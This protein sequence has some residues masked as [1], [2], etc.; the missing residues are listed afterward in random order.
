MTEEVAEI[1]SLAVWGVKMMAAS[2]RNS[3]YFFR[4]RDESG[5]S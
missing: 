3:P 2:Y 4:A 1:T 5:S